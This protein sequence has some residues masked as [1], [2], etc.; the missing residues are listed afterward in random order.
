MLRQ[1]TIQRPFSGPH[2]FLKKNLNCRI[3]SIQLSTISN[4]GG[5]DNPY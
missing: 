1:A 2:I 4:L 5:E 3:L